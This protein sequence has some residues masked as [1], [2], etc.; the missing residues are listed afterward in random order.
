MK[1]ANTLKEKCLSPGMLGNKS[2]NKGAG[3]YSFYLLNTSPE[4]I[5]K[6]KRKQR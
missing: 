2:S 4:Q 5:N 6:N 1:P 3:W